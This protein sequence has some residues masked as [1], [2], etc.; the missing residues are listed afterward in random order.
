MI[1]GLVR[2]YNDSVGKLNFES[3]KGEAEAVTLK[4]QSSPS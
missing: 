1:P 4:A 2:H 3:E